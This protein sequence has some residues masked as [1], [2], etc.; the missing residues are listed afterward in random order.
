MQENLLLILAYFAIYL[1]CHL[2]LQTTPEAERLLLSNSASRLFIEALVQNPLLEPEIPELLS[3]Y[4]PRPLDVRIESPA[5]LQPERVSFES[6]D[7]DSVLHGNRLIDT[8][9]NRFFD[10]VMSQDQEVCNVAYDHDASWQY[11]GESAQPSS[12]TKTYSISPSLH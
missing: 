7:D 3:T 2:K 4:D 12:T 10:S 1:G 11:W 6:F 9:C 8:H 5:V